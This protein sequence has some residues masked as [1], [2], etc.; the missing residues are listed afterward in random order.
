MTR[1]SNEKRRGSRS[2]NSEI[3]TAPNE[4]AFSATPRHQQPLGAPMN[5]SSRARSR[6]RVQKV[7][8]GEPLGEPQNLIGRLAWTMRLLIKA[9]E[10]GVSSLDHV[11][12]RLSDYVFKLRRRGYAIETIDTKHGGEFPGVHAVY[13][14]HSEVRVLEGQAA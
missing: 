9:G 11:G 4:I 12:P 3:P 10:Q 2:P 13:R 8:A 7:D 6:L 5:S 1:V 14:L